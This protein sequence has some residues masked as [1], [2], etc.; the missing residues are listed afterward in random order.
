MI[1][2]MT[3]YGRGDFENENYRITAEM[4]TVNHRYCDII[5]KM[6]KKLISLEERMKALIKE[7]INRG[8]VEVYINYDEIEKNEYRVSPNFAVLDQYHNALLE[9]KGK[10]DIKDP[11]SLSLL[12]KYPDALDVTYEETD[13]EAVWVVME[14]ALNRALDSVVAMREVEGEKL[15]EDVISRIEMLKDMLSSIEALVPEIVQGHKSKMIERIRELLDGEIEVDQDRIIHEVAVY[16]DKTSIAEEVV[17]LLSHFDQ[18]RHFL[19]KGGNVGRKLDFLVQE[20]N[21]E[22][23]TIGSKS[24]DI[25]ISNYVIEMKSEVEKIREQIQNIE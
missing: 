1:L 16:A 8:R 18:L 23:N 5:I 15:K 13:Q 19:D 22:V 7:K 6:P 24:P 12:S 4:K 25:D 3:G 20:L 17:R 2:S 10:Y 11:V 9:I 21:R 14:A